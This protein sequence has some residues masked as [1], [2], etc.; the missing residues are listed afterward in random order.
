M[1]NFGN[2]CPVAVLNIKSISLLELFLLRHM[3][4][5]ILLAA[6][7]Q[8]AAVIFLAAAIQVEAVILLAAAIQVIS[9]I[10]LAA[11]AAVVL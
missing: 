10:Q 8:I 9:V 11:S 7:I 1:S 4:A 5:V 3:A 2:C 6:A